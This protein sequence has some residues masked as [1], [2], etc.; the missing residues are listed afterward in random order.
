MA[1]G[2]LNLF[3]RM[4]V[5]WRDLHPYN[6]VHVVWLPARLDAARL[7]GRVAHE[8]EARGLTGLVVDE[9]RAR[10][11][12]QGGAASVEVP[13]VADD[14]D[15]LG[16]LTREI[17][18][19][20]NAP[21]PRTSPATPFRFFAMQGEGGFHLGLAYDHFVAGGDAIARLLTGIARGYLAD[22][23]AST[24]E[25]LVLYPAT[26]RTLFLRHPLWALGALAGLPRMVAASRR[27][28]RPGYADACDAHNAF[29][30]FRIGPQETRALVGA[31]KAWGVTV[32]DLLMASL[33]CAL[34]PLSADRRRA[35]RRN[36][37]AVAAIV[38]IRRDLPGEAGN[39]L[40]PFLAAFR[41]GHSVPEG[42]GLRQ[43]AD[44]VHEDTARI[45]RRHLY[46][47]GILALG[48]SAL[49]WPLLSVRQRHRFY[50]K[51]Y[52]SWAGVT[53][54]NLN[55]IWRDPGA[56]AMA[57]LY[58]MRAVPTGPLCPMVFAVTTVRDVLHVGV[59]FRTTAFSRAAIDGIAEHFVRCI[60]T[61]HAEPA[62]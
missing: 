11:R 29:K 33:L 45:K 25:A 28:L 50:P 21:F 3:Q 9:A 37:V 61:L 27:A 53:T 51:H 15:A 42:I 36:Q 47:Q 18:R 44:E 40:S 32:N 14:G 12:Y 59:S 58:Y 20:F 6:P 7:R 41:V 26:Y 1:G 17:E 34:A 39:A 62:A 46:L 57:P 55:E 2:R 48:V 4:M 5:R 52:P 24:P 60:E 30:Y 38:N 22:G 56:D 49:M 13:V 23:G 10:F 16:A 19:Q 8:L 43:L 54:L 35:A 31:G